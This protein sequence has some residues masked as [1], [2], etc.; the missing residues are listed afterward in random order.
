MLNS[1]IAPQGL[2]AQDCSRICIRN[3]HTMGTSGLPDTVNT[4]EAGGPQAQ[5]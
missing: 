3:N 1:F 4:P 5:D 2:Y